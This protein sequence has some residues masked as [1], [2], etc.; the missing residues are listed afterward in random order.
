MGTLN[1][2]AQHRGKKGYVWFFGSL[3]PRW[4]LD[5][6]VYPSSLPPRTKSWLCNARKDA[7]CY[8]TLDCHALPYIRTTKGM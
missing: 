1:S 8:T 4:N 7:A 5:L 2:T 6:F 3:V